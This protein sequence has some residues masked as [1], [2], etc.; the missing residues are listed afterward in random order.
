M[1][2]KMYYT[3][4]LKLVHIPAKCGHYNSSYVKAGIGYRADLTSI[5]GETSQQ[6]CS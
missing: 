6:N 2:G 3:R 1:A 4:P 5:L